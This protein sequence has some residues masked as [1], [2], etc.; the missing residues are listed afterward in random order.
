MLK[1]NMQ[2][3]AL[4]GADLVV[5][6]RPQGVLGPG[7]GKGV[8]HGLH[9]IQV[10]AERGEI[11]AQGQGGHVRIRHADDGQQAKQ[12][13]LIRCLGGGVTT[14]GHSFAGGDRPGLAL[15]CMRVQYYG[16]D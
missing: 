12:A 13:V 10:Q 9:T 6:V 7:G 3:L 11:S 1:M 15:Q 2:M 5:G 8:I 14:A 4:T 16:P